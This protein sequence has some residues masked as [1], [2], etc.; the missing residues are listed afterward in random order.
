[1]DV[2][3]YSRKISERSGKD[4]REKFYYLREYIYYHERIVGRTMSIKNT[5][6][7][8]EGNKEHAY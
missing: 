8:S 1:M 7:V 4:S 6:E 5:I 2:L 3:V